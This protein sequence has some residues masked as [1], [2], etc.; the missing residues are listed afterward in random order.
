MSSVRVEVP[1]STSVLFPPVLR[2]LIFVDLRRS[3]AVGRVVARVPPVEQQSAPAQP[4]R[5]RTRQLLAAEGRRHTRSQVR[6][7]Q[8]RQG[9]GRPG[10]EPGTHGHRRQGPGAGRR[11]RAGTLPEGIQR[12]RQDGRHVSLIRLITIVTC[13]LYR[14]FDVCVYNVNP[15]QKKPI[16]SPARCWVTF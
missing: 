3:L 14:V 13:A 5:P 6:R 11:P 2:W 15:E 1:A 8:D 4:Q 16:R 9:S 12:R 7:G 10:P